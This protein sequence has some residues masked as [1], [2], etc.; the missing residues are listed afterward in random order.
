MRH[1]LGMDGM[2]IVGESC[3]QERGPLTLSVLPMKIGSMVFL[4][5]S[6]FTSFGCTKGE[7]QKI[8][9]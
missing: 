1:K 8:Q 4:R 9:Q 2:I 5:C 3:D 6:K 7:T